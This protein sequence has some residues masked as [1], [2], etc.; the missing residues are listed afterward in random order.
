[1]E[2][3]EAGHFHLH[4][5]WDFE[6]NSHQEHRSP[7]EGPWLLLNFRVQVPQGGSQV[8]RKEEL[9]RED[10]LEGVT[11]AEDGWWSQAEKRGAGCGVVKQPC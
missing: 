8:P 6:R 4:I 3:T 1:M 5:I 10:D 7:R 9:A 11:G 2:K